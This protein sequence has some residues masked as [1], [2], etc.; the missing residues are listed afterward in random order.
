MRSQSIHVVVPLW[1][2]FFWMLFL[3]KWKVM[4]H[5]YTIDIQ[6]NIQALCR[7]GRFIVVVAKVLSPSQQ[8][9]LGRPV[10]HGGLTWPLFQFCKLIGKRLY[11]AGK[12]LKIICFHLFGLAYGGLRPF[13]HVVG[14]LCWFF[15]CDD[16]HCML[17]LLHC[18]RLF[19]CFIQSWFCSSFLHFL[20]ISIIG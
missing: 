2:C 16:Y 17:V 1:A 12:D 13:P 7:L 11:S 18:D 3:M 6:H 20:S 14:V 8:V 4:I 15:I 10:A 9:E 5:A 19:K